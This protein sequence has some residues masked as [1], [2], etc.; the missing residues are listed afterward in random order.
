MERL[1]VGLGRFYERLSLKKTVEE[2]GSPLLKSV[3]PFWAL[4][5]CIDSLEFFIGSFSKLNLIYHYI[6]LSS[7]IQAKFGVFP[8]F[9]F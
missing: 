2:T 7:F 8:D 9:S 1:A 4:L 6:P 3:I 5:I